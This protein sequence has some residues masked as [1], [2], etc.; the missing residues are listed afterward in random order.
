[1]VLQAVPFPYVGSFTTVGAPV[2]TNA[3][4][5]FSFDVPG[6]SQTTKLR[7][8]T[9][10]APP[11]VSQAVTE[12]VAVLVTLRARPTRS[13]GLVRLEG[14]VAPTEVGVPVAFQWMRPTR[15]PVSVADTVVRRGTARV[16]RFSA[17]VSIRHSGSYRALVKVNNGKQVSGSSRTVLLRGTPVV[18]KV[19][20]AHARH[21]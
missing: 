2:S 5:G 12:R 9:L 6:V 20:R 21:R 8:Q 10:N 15:R 7:V 14:T 16:S 11:T 19:R 17:V 3:A 18:H 13:P 1:M 4:G